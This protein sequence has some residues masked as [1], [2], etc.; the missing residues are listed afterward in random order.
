MRPI[1]HPLVPAGPGHRSPQTMLALDERDALLREA[2]DRFCVGMS[3]R[4]AAA[5]L[6]VRL[7]RYAECAWRRERGEALCPPR[8][9]GTITG[10]LWMILKARDRVPS[11]RL[12]RYVLA[13]A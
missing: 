5:Y 4:A 3:D 1:R 2:A 7:T 13:R 6:S 11:E 10:L 8:H 12:I 9:V